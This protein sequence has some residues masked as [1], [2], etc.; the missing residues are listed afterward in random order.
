PAFKKQFNI[1]SLG[2]L[3]FILEFLAYLHGLKTLAE[4]T[5]RLHLT[6]IS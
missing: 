4:T 2:L 5:G 3:R 6:T 1:S